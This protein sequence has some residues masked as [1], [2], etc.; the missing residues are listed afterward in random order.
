MALQ[1]IR[2]VPQRR[3]D[4][5]A[6]AYKPGLS[7]F[8]R[9]GIYLAPDGTDATGRR[10]SAAAVVVLPD[11][12][13]FLVETELAPAAIAGAMVKVNLFR[14][15]AGWRWIDAP[16]GWDGLQNLVS[17]ESGGRHHYCLRALF[18]DGLLLARYPDL[19]SEPRLRPTARG[20]INLGSKIGIVSVRGRESP[21][22]QEVTVRGGPA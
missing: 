16:S 4:P 12:A 17:V 6:R 3:L 7:P 10:A 9:G 13:S 2:V 20:T 22:F 5:S 11:A 8:V 1:P 15:S 14:R 18:P 19:R 21:V